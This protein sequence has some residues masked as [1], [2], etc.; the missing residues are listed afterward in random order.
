[1][2]FQNDEQFGQITE[3]KKEEKPKLPENS[4]QPSHSS[5]HG[6]ADKIFGIMIIILGIAFLLSLI[7]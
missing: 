6:N 4:N 1:M 7:Y 3:A 2:E 5:N